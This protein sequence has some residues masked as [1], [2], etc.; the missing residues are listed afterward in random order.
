[1]LH[2]LRVIALIALALLALPVLAGA[3][4]TDSS[5]TD[6]IFLRAQRLVSEGQGDA[7]RALVA[8]RLAAAAPGSADY[9]E[10]LY[11]RAVLAATAADAERDYKRLIIEFPVSHRAEEALLRLAQLEMSR[12]DRVQAMRHLE[13]LLLEHPGGRSRARA[14]YWMARVLLDEGKLPAACVR[15]ADARASTP[16][17][18]VELRNQIEYQSQRCA[19]VDTTGA[20]VAAATVTAAGP[21]ARGGVA[22]R[23]VAG[24]PRDSTPRDSTPRD[25][26]PRDSTPR[27]STPRDTIATQTETPAAAQPETPVPARPRARAE[28][29]I[30]VGAYGSRNTA[31]GVQTRLRERGLEARIV[32]S[33]NLHRVRIGRYATRDRADE[34]AARVKAAGFSAF[35]TEAEPR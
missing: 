15:L 28:Y 35:V 25:S 21:P 4:Q 1:M 7:G 17:G 30:Q 12:G 33:G 26:T 10:A 27:D 3:Q 11:W 22:G 20:R 13:R 18:D 2:S 23:P 32:T 14:N 34:A 31:A 24:T 9:V 8:Q 29:T 19:G 16:D 5:P 6:T